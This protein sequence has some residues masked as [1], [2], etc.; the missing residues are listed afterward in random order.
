M[1]EGDTILRAARALHN[2][3][4]GQTVISLETVLP[5]LARVDYDSGVTGR[6]IE[7]VEARGKWMMI[8]FSGDLILLTHMLMSGSWHIYRPEVPWKRRSIHRR[9]VIGTDKYVAVAFNVPIAEFH[10][11][12]TL[13]KHPRLRKLGPSVLAKEFDDAT[14]LRNL[15]AQSEAEVGAALLNQTV[16]AGIGNVFK[17][18]VCFGCS[19]NPFR[20]V[21]S[22]TIQEMACL[23]GTARKFMLAN[24]THAS[25]DKTVTYNTLRRTTGCA[26]PE[27]RMWVYSR[28]GQQCHRC[29]TAIE[30]RKQNPGAR[31]TYWCPKCQP[32]V[33]I[34]QSLAA[35]RWEGHS[36]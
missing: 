11:A 2:A 15:R 10:N 24:V 1:P 29:G 8:Y 14:I 28:C 25:S 19:V 13:Q 31:T 27:D 4:A 17:S 34:E 26:G 36:R 30:S 22:L 16:L 12:S 7:K 5:K 9:I 21:E 33:K 32:M 23:V 20:R 18:E 6:T 35:G 3:L